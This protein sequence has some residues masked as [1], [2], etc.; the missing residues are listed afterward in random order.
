MRIL[1]ILIIAVIGISVFSYTKGTDPTIDTNY[2]NSDENIVQNCINE[3][4]IDSFIYYANEFTNILNNSENRRLLLDSVVLFSTVENNNINSLN[5]YYT[6]IEVT[7]GI[8][9]ITSQ[10]FGYYSNIVLQQLQ[11]ENI[12][13]HPIADRYFYLIESGCIIS[14]IEFDGFYSSVDYSG[15]YLRGGGCGFW[16]V[17]G[18]T[19]GLAASVAGEVTV[20]TWTLGT[21]T[22]M[23]ASLI[24]TGISYGNAIADCF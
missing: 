22:I 12:N 21:G 19:I 13:Y 18:N 10:K 23:A 16:S 2:N 6:W 1:K 9:T 24:T 11:L 14:S 8:P 20:E 3:N 15:A 4:S 5:L 7:F 17:F